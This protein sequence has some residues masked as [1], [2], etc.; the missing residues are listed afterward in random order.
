MITDKYKILKKTK[1][2]REISGEKV[3]LILVAWYEPR[4]K[5][6]SYYGIHIQTEKGYLFKGDY[7][8]TQV[9]AEM[10][11]LKI[12]TVYHKKAWEGV[13]LQKEKNP[14]MQ[15]DTINAGGFPETLRYLHY[16]KYINNVKT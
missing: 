9:G 16:N 15:R 6:P 14:K 13:S 12:M 7:F 11:I 10:G 3:R 4:A 2:I 8:Q 1:F 5:K